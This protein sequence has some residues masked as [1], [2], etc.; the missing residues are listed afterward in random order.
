MKRKKDCKRLATLQGELF[1]EALSDEVAC[2]TRDCLHAM[3]MAFESRYLSQLMR[4]QRSKQTL[5]DSEHPWRTPPP[6]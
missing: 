3:L 5:Y 6:L 1:P 4:H 2:A